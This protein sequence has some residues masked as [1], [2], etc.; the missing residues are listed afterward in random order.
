[1]SGYKDVLGLHI[2]EAETGKFLLSAMNELKKRGTEDIL[3][4][5]VDG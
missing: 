1:M 5:S 2:D 4:C 3:I